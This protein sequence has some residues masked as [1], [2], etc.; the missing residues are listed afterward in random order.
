[1]NR[2][3]LKKIIKEAILELVSEG[4]IEVSAPSLNSKAGQADFR[5]ST[6]HLAEMIRTNAKQVQETRP[7]NQ[8]EAALLNL[9]A[10][11]AQTTYTKQVET[12]KFGQTLEEKQRF[13]SMFPDELV[14]HFNKMFES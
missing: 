6:N 3:E 12:E 4:K 1:M 2:N 13:D 10:D 11:T 5:R 7:G 8:K 14:E 9:L